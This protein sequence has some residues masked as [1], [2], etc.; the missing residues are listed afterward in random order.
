MPT[1]QPPE[2]KPPGWAQ[3]LSEPDQRKKLLQKWLELI[4]SDPI[5]RPSGEPLEQLAFLCERF[6]DAFV[7]ALASPP[8]DSSLPAFRD[9]VKAISVIGGWLAE[10]RAPASWPIVMLRS[11]REAVRL[12][13]GPRGAGEEM[14]ELVTQLMAS[15]AETY[16]MTVRMN[17]HES[18]QE[19]LRRATPILRIQDDLPILV[20]VG[21][22]EPPIIGEAFDRLLVEMVRADGPGAIVDL[23]CLV[24][25][26]AALL[27]CLSSNLAELTANE[28]V[29]GRCVYLTGA[30]P[31]MAEQ[32]YD[33]GVDPDG[34]AVAPSIEDAATSLRS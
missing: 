8:W 11:L 31:V 2:P 13:V 34:V 10:S 9:T 27:R 29:S 33:Q 30:T 7:E 23:S 12:T 26:G 6:V 18:H 1:G 16:A 19:V 17:L 22:P 3:E 14:I 32:L 25:K 4:Q 24:E 28:R 21:D 20:L 5:F 15:A